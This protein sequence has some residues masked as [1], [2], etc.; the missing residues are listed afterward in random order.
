MNKINNQV[1]KNG[2]LQKTVCNIRLPEIVY[3]FIL[4]E[5]NTSFPIPA[6]EI[7]RRIGAKISLDKTI[8]RSCLLVLC[9]AGALSI[10]NVGREQFIEV[11]K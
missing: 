4:R 2:G 5:F 8:I 11:I 7:Y 1:N 10:R 6:S 9:K 3:G